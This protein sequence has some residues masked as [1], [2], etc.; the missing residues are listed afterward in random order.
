MNPLVYEISKAH[1]A[2][3]DLSISDKSLN[4]DDIDKLSDIIPNFARFSYELFGLLLNSATPIESTQ[5]DA[6]WAEEVANQ[7]V[8]HHQFSVLQS[9]VEGYLDAGYG[10]NAA[11]K[12]LAEGLLSDELSPETT[13]VNL[14]TLRSLM[15]FYEAGSAEYEKIKAQGVANKKAWAAYGEKLANSGELGILIDAA[16][17]SAISAIEY[18]KHV[19][20]VFSPEHLEEI[21]DGASGDFD[22]KKR[23]GEIVEKSSKLKAVIDLAGKLKLRAAAK[24]KELSKSLKHQIDDVVVGDDYSS[25]CPSE[26]VNPLMPVKFATGELLS[27]SKTGHD[28]RAKGSL[29]LILDSTGS[30]S[31]FP[32]IWTKAVVLVIAAI[33]ESEARDFV[34][35]HYGDGVLKEQYFKSGE[36]NTKELLECVNYFASA[37][38]NN[39]RP[40]F[41]R[42]LDIIKEDALF[43]KSDLVF[44]TDG[45]C[46]WYNYRDKKRSKDE[47]FTWYQNQLD[48]YSITPYGV[49]VGDTIDDDLLQVTENWIKV[50]RDRETD[51]AIDNLWGI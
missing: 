19:Q 10:M 25:V 18:Q 23:L 50:G 39:E 13:L 33:A 12:V 51:E 35:L 42:A 30:L 27:F 24:R 46:E 34:V 7:F 15:G 20:Y 48:E 14:S 4:A 44:L 28:T 49:L 17:T 6:I 47:W 9:A 36:D 31:G 22:S 1:Q 38:T 5:A 32:E 3:W 26:W 41:E 21:P 29:V 37:S 8:S 40:A 11:I 2:Y 45:G 43:S 16:I